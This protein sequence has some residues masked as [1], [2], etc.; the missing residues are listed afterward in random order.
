VSEIPELPNLEEEM[1]IALHPDLVP[2][3]GSMGTAGMRALRHPLVFDVPYF[4]LNGRL[5]NRYEV[6]KAEVDAALAEK[7]WAKVIFT[8]ERPYR[9][10]ILRAHAQTIMDQ[11]Q[12]LFW[13]IL[14]EVWTDTENFWQSLDEWRDMWGDMWSDDEMEHRREAMDDSERA[15]LDGLPEVITVY[16]GISYLPQISG[17]SWS[18]DRDKAMWFARRYR[19]TEHRVLLTGEVAKS[20]VLAHFLGRGEFEIVALPENVEVINE[21]ALTDD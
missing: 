1:K 18:L 3:L 6:M 9:A 15:A 5:N 8:H 12:K 20:D 19:Q 21:D 11:D 14:G 10:D 17:L 7:N 2:Y 16:R 4:G 13:S